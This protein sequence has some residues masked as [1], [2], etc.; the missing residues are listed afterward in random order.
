MRST[1][2]L[3]ERFRELYRA[4]PERAAFAP[5]RVNLIGEHTD[6][7]GGHVLPCALEQGISCAV[8]RR[9]DGKLRFY[10]MDIPGAGVIERE[11][12]RL[13][14]LS[15]EEWTAYP[16]GV[17][18][19]MA[20]AGYPL[21][22]GLDL[23]FY[24]DIPAGMGLSSSAALEV[25]TGAA[26]ASLFGFNI[27]NKDLALIGKRAEN[28]YVGVNCGIMDQFA[29]AMGRRG[30]A[31]FLDTATL[32]YAYA[33]LR[34]PDHELVIIDSRVKHS[35]AGSAY[36]DRRRE[37][38]TALS[39]LGTVLETDALCHISPD[40]FE[41]VC[42]VIEDPIILKRARHA[43][44]EDDRTVRAL[45]ALTKNDIWEFGRLMNESHISLRDDYEVSCPELDIL[46]ELA[47]AVPGCVGARMTG[48]GF[49]GCMVAIVEKAAVKGFVESI[50]DEYRKRTALEARAIIAE[51]GE[52]AHVVY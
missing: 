8:R 31:V 5:G 41:A 29:S 7:N 23:L 46:T 18:W 3:I 45:E 47:W 38:E 37:C 25:A 32:E 15:S 27:D 30:N 50:T 34:M 1:E 51:P 36:N 11:L 52:G 26:V 20:E 40:Q 19:A 9:A 2:L 4:E 14:P 21:P 39:L 33:P 48:G 42:G 16:E 24:G 43:V 17:I 44:Y 28:A 10:S 6:Y 49:G 12:S 35:L 22:C 13:A